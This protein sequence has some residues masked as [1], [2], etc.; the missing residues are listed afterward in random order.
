V[1]SSVKAGGRVLHLSLDHQ[2]ILRSQLSEVS[3]VASILPGHQVS[4]LVTAVVSNGL[5]VKICGFFDGTIDLTHLGLGE[6]EIEEKHKVGKKVSSL[7]TA[8]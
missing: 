2:A 7:P 5:N 3:N 1:I 6:A 8:W 4:V